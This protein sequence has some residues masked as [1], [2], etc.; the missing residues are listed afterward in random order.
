MT[1]RGRQRYLNYLKVL[2]QV[3]RDAAQAAKRGPAPH[4][5][6][7]GQRRLKPT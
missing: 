6:S 3:V 5:P 1:A 2:E 7:V 4:V